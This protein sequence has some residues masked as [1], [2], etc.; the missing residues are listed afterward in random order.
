MDLASDEKLQELNRLI[1]TEADP[2]KMAALAEEFSVRLK[3]L[4]ERDS[5]QFSDGGSTPPESR[6]DKRQQGQ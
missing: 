3:E 1:Q 2:K 5:G 6:H 4:Q